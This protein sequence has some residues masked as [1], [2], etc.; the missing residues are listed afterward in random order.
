MF[1][2]YPLSHTDPQGRVWHPYAVKFES[3]DGPFECHIYAISDDHARLQLEALKET[4]QINGQT[5]GA[6]DA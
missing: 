5:I 6:Y 1:L 2:P 4:G 3:P